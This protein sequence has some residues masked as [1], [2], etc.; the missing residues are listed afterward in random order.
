MLQMVISDIKV[1]VV[2]KNIKNI[3]LGV[4]P[5]NGRVRISAP[6]LVK[7]ETIKILVSTKISWIRRQQRKFK[8]QLRQSPREYK[9]RES[10]YYLGKRYLLKVI[11]VNTVPNVTIQTVNTLILS[12]RPESDKEKRRQV[13]DKWYREKLR[14][15][16]PDLINKWETILEVKVNEF[17]IKQMK[18]KWGTCNIAAKRIWL[19]LELAKK[20]LHCLE[21]IIVH[22]MMHLLERHHNE[23]YKKLLDSYM[24]KWR[25]YKDELNWFPISHPNWEY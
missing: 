18:T 25:T 14:E 15:L 16:I 17:G 4:Y 9:D 8:E 6:L 11:E 24:P 21:Y 20:P 22:E 10:H 13:M 7:D 23:R 3:H 12:I 19:N 5:P 1:D 2:R